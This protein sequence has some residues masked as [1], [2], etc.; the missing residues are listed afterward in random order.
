MGAIIKRTVTIRSAERRAEAILEWTDRP[1]WR[2]T[3]SIPGL[4]PF[5]SLAYDLFECFTDVRERAASSGW[6]ICVVGA[7]RDAWPSG[8]SSDMGGAALVYI[9]TLGRQADGDDLRPIFDDAPCELIGSAEEQKKF[10]TQWRE[11]LRR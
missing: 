2:V 5:E 1:P 3:L 7:R 10:R 4:D 8:M 6:Q 11:S 9:H